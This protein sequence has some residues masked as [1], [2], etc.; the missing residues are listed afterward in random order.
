MTY[1]KQVYWSENIFYSTQV[2]MVTVIN[3]SSC[4]LQERYPSLIESVNCSG[5]LTS[6]IFNDT[7]IRQ[8]AELALLNAGTFKLLDVGTLKLHNAMQARLNVSLK[9]RLFNWLLA[10][11]TEC[12][13][14]SCCVNLSVHNASHKRDYDVLK[15]E[16]VMW[17]TWHMARLQIFVC[18]C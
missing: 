17:L 12:Y 1:G 5:I 15:S 6:I 3:I 16:W 10:Y 2:I 11:P 13:K 9:V 4:I 8:H 18:C 14:F 7:I